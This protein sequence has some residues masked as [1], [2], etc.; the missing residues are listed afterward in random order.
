M[1]AL[2]LKNCLTELVCVPSINFP[3][4]VKYSHFIETNSALYLFLLQLSCKYPF[5]PLSL[6]RLFSE[7]Q[8]LQIQQFPVGFG[9]RLQKK[10]KVMAN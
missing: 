10:F 3:L 1:K 4:S 9:S 8:R 7:F 2:E 6:A 5:S